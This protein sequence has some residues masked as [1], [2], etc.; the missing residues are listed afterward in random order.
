MTENNNQNKS[1]FS[2][3]KNGNNM[4]KPP[5]FNAYWIY[6]L[7]AVAFIALNLLDLGQS[8]K[9]TSWQKVK[10]EMIRNQ[11]VDRIVVVRNLLEVNV[12]LRKESLDKYPDLFESS[13][14]SPSKAGPHYTF[15]IGSI[16]QFA[17][18]LDKAQERISEYDRI[19]PEYTTHENYFGDFIGWILPF[20]L[21]I[22][23]WFYVFRRMSRGAGGGGG[24]GNIFN[25]GKS[26]AK[27]FDKESNINV[28]FNDVAGLAEAK[29]EVEE[30]VEFLKHPQRYTKL[31]GKIPK[32][33]LLVG[34]PGTGKTLLAK[35]V[36]GEANVPFFSMSGSDF[37]EMF[38]GVGASRVRDLFKQ[39]K[40]KAPCI[41][42][43]DEIDA[44]GRARGKNPNMGSNDERENT[45][46]QL[47]TEMD[48]FDTN[49]GVI[50]LAATNRAD[51]LD[52]ALMRAG[53]FDRQ[54]HVEL[55]DLNE[56]RE[57]FNVH[58]K[59]LKL[60]PK[61]DQEF[62]AKQTPGFS[63]ADIAN[64][65]NEAALIAARKKKD[66]I[67]KQDFLDAIDRII[68]GLEK[69]N[70][71]ISLQEKKTIAYHEAGHATISWLLEHAHPLVKVTIVPRGKALG[72]AWYLP[73]ERSITT[74]EQMLDEMCSTLG[75]R[76]AEEITF[77]KVSTGAQNDLE[78]VTKQ[79]I[80]MV[81]IFGMSD[82]VGNVSYYDSSGQSD[83][84]FSKPYSEK[85]A[86]LIDQEVKTLIENS[87][88]RAKQVLRDNEEKH[89]KL[90]ELLLER[91]VIFSEDLEEIF[92]KRNFGKE[93]QVEEKKIVPPTIKPPKDDNESK[94]V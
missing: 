21:I 90:A 43:I 86:E 45:L 41:V 49:S 13:F 48:G 16:E 22:G 62:L 92:G 30:I 38:V 74:K 20:A 36:A 67:E 44:I 84:S 35:A 55:P 60:D 33:A 23:I 79:A 77:G 2:K 88:E 18:Q 58:L 28:N 68:G 94:A 34:P 52:R 57:I 80:A 50:I 73:E 72:A 26:K 85:T 12:Y 39:A 82:K 15:P 63:G 78:K 66:I 14:D 75:G 89:N 3:G 51:I 40:E 54:I 87:Y 11:D 10:N 32:G 1:P 65:C 69:K 31:G 70:K 8:P 64:V 6:G 4:I 17:E 19:E 7:I 93:E 46:N 91:E 76:A 25:V 81:S 59:P 42:F 61:I 27:V 53:R 9:E 71:I 37:V 83:Y 5:K 56:R 24:G 47:L 29:Q